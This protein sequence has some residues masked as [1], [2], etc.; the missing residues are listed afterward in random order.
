MNGLFLNW[1]VCTLSGGQHAPR[2]YTIIITWMM[3]DRAIPGCISTM[4]RYFSKHSNNHHDSPQEF[5]KNLGNFFIRNKTGNKIKCNSLPQQFL[6]IAPIYIQMSHQFVQRWP[7][8]LPARRAITILAKISVAP[9]RKV[10]S[11]I[12]TSCNIREEPPVCRVVMV[13]GMRQRED[14]LLMPDRHSVPLCRL[15]RYLPTFQVYHDD[16]L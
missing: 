9:Q 10:P 5:S 1:K 8:K 16:Q 6:P 14:I 11:Y 13:V 4:D 12:K 7:V 2:V 3:L 15:S